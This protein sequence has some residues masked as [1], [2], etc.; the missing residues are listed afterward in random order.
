MKEEKETVEEVWRALFRLMEEGKFKETVYS[1]RRFKGL[2]S[3]S[4]ALRMLG[5]RET[6]GKVIVEVPNDEKG[7]L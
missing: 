5:S 2:E 6:W 7:K 3:V 1:D 4:E